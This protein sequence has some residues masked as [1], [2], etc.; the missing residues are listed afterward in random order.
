M[1]K[2]EGKILG[3]IEAGG[4]KFVC[5][6]RNNDLYIIEKVSFPKKSEDNG[7]SNC[8]RCDDF[9]WWRDETVSYAR[10]NLS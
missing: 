7:V 10:K 5:G 4:T 1:C 6:I 8:A 2:D 9:W 3:S